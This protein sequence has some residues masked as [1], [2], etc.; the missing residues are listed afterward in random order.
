MLGFSAEHS[1][2]IIRA[3]DEAVSNIMRHSYR[4]RLDQPIE[5]YCNRLHRRADGEM[6]LGVEILLFDCGPPVDTTKLPA[7]SL[8]EIRPGGLGLHIIRGS[9]DTVQYKRAGRLNRLRLVKYARSSKGGCGS[10][11]EKPS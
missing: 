11:E 6:E 2:E 8:D 4:G 5:V 10:A 9:M 3:V 1:R 7:R